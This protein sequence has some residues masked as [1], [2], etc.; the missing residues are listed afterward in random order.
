MDLIYGSP[1]DVG[2]VAAPPD[3]PPPR[4]AQDAAPGQEESCPLRPSPVP[5]ASRPLRSEP[6]ALVKR[7]KMQPMIKKPDVAQALRETLISP[8]EC[9]SNLE[10]ANVV[11][12]LFAIARALVAVAK[13][14]ESARRER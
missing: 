14:I 10:P 9:D 2:K 8:N 5:V 11:D 13:A 7:G 3:L 12:G 1:A 6:V 4:R